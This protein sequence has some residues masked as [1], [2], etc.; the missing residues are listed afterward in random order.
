MLGSTQTGLG[1]VPTAAGDDSPGE[2]LIETLAAIYTAGLADSLDDNFFPMPSGNLRFWGSTASGGYPGWAYLESASTPG[3]NRV[4]A[5]FVRRYYQTSLGIGGF[6]AREIEGYDPAWNGTFSGMGGVDITS[7]Q[8][9]F[10]SNDN[11]ISADGGRM[12]IGSITWKEISGFFDGPLNYP[13]P[14]FNSGAREDFT[15]NLWN[16]N[17]S[18]MA[19]RFGFNG[20]GQ[21]MTQPQPNAHGLTSAFDTSIDP[22]YLPASGVGDGVAW[23]VRYGGNMYSVADPPKASLGAYKVDGDPTHGWGWTINGTSAS[24]TYGAVAS[25][26]FENGAVFN[27]GLKFTTGTVAPGATVVTI[28]NSPGSSATPVEYLAIKTAGGTRYIALLA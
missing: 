9:S 24:N 15:L 13:T 16:G 23:H 4:G 6:I 10:G 14:G 1:S 7:D 19:L 2:E 28:S 18:S 3:D 8:V 22:T 5:E 21:I 11:Q 26:D 25:F 17:S 27:T 12:R 20:W